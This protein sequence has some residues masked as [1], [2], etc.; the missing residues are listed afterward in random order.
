MSTPVKLE[1][2]SGPADRRLVWGLFQ[3]RTCILPTWRGVLILLAGAAI[4]VAVL[5]RV[6]DP[7]LAVTEPVESKWLVVEGWMP[8]YGLKAATEVF[9][10]GQYQRLYV[11]GIPLD[12]GE[13]LSQ[14]HTYAELGAATL[15]HLGM[16]TNALQA[17]PGPDVLRDRTYAS[18]VALKRWMQNHSGTPASLNVISLGPHARRTRLMYEEAFGEGTRIGIISLPDRSYKGRPWWTTSR[19]FR[20]TT[21]ELIAYIY[22]RF[23][24]HPTEAP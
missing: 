23:F 16:N 3:R 6:V 17:V 24:F 5:L 2:M 12:Q 21:G 14:Y 18:A 1:R 9:Q 13:P 10:R 19:G 22:A 11:T 20:D 15:T 8:D 7:F 4:L